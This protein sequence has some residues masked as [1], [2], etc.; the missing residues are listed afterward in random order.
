MDVTNVKQLHFPVWSEMEE[1]H[2]WMKSSG[3]Q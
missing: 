2:S 1:K 3:F